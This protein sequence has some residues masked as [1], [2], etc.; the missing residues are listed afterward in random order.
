MR[1]IFTVHTKSSKNFIENTIFI[2]EGFSM[3]AAIFN[4]FWALYY[5]IWWLA[6]V[7]LLL[8]IFLTF[9]E[10]KH[11]IN[12]LYI[13]VMHFLVNIAIG[14]YANDF[15]RKDLQNKGYK[16]IDIISG[17]DLSEAEFRFFEK[18]TR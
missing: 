5:K 17:K 12:N 13:M 7:T 1:K 15:Y 14:F 4:I 18:I 2:E 6:T 8:N 3:K 9:V 11:Y 16:M 10:S